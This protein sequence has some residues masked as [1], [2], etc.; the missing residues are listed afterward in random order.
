MNENHLTDDE[1][2][3]VVVGAPSRRASDHLASCESCRTEESRMR[4][5][6]KGF[7]EEY[8][9]QGE[10]PE[11]FWAKQRAAVHARIERR[12]TVLWRLTWSTAAAATIM[13][14]YLHFRSPASQPAPV[15]QDADQA[16]L[17]DVERSLRR[18]V[19]AA[20][21]PAMILAAEIDRMA[22][23]EQVNEKGETQ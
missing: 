9:R 17:L 14:G 18:P 12:R 3:G 16:L 10:R 1:L 19:P 2:A 13:L 23:I 6:L 21:E 5:E 11:V 15:V 20:L 4:S 8:A 7:S 22:S